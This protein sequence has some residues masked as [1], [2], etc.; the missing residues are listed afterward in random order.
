MSFKD[1]LFQTNSIYSLIFIRIAFGIAAFWE[2]YNTTFTGLVY[3]YYVIP[4]FH[5]TYYGFEWIPRLPVEYLPWLF[6]VLMVLSVLVIIGLF[7]RISIILFTL[8]FTYIF[9]IEKATYLNHFYMIILCGV[10]L[11]IMP[12]NRYFSFDSYFNPKIK[13][14]K[15]AFWPIFLL[16]CQIEIMLIFAGL[17]KVN[18]DWLLR[19][20]PLKIWLGEY[21]TIEPLHYLFTQDWSLMMISWGVVILHLAGAPLLLW[22][23]TRIYIFVIY[24]VFHVSNHFIFHVGSFPWM[25]IGVTTIFFAA[26]W[27][28]K[29]FKFFD[30]SEEISSFEKPSLLMQKILISFMAIWIAVQTLVPLRFLLY[31]NPSLV[32][33]TNEGHRFAW[34]MKLNAFYSHTS[35]YVTDLD[36]RE[37]EQVRISDYL[38]LRQFETMECQPDM[39]LEFAHYIH[40]VWTQEKGYKNVGVSVKAL[41]S[42]NGREYKL[43]IDPDADLAHIERSLKHN[44]W[45]LPLDL[46]SPQ[47]DLKSRQGQVMKKQKVCHP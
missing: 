23:R 22:N 3:N 45:V 10:L 39:M 17:V 5:F 13:T 1:K 28:K 7:Y 24:C 26:D 20:Q 44:E 31:P 11:S 21:K 18:Y 40:K 19:S 41:C 35:F 47:V 14:E 32:S 27:P 30:K 33:W 29:I 37:R 8:G 4:K 12:A 42:M 34:R 9:L 46:E 36:S 15:I 2:C 25:T 16:R 6:C 38:T 43:M